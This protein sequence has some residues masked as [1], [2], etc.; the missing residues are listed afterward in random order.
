MQQRNA[1][2]VQLID[3]IFDYK[4]SLL[5]ALVHL[6]NVMVRVSRSFAALFA[7]VITRRLL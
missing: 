7:D 1:T 2:T 6:P 5:T 3:D 4:Q